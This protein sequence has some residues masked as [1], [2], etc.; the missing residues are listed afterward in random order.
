MQFL[1]D[2]L[3]RPQGILRRPRFLPLH[4]R[5]IAHRA[6]RRPRLIAGNAQ[7]RVQVLYL[8]SAKSQRFGGVG[9][10]RKR[11]GNG[12]IGGNRLLKRLLI[13]FP[14]D[15]VLEN[16]HIRHRRRLPLSGK[17]KAARGRLKLS[18]EVDNSK[19]HG[20]RV[21]LQQAQ[22]QFVRNPRLFFSGDLEFQKVPQRPQRQAEKE[23]AKQHRQRRQ[24]QAEIL[25]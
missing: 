7:L 16:T 8:I 11:S 23:A 2:L 22:Q 21:S 15:I 25:V 9:Y 1:R 13:R 20:T 12:L 6:G 17:Q 18:T 14:L 5:Q 24:K 4:A 19:T 10:R 3:L